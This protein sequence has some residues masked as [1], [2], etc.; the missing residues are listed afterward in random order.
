MRKKITFKI[1]VIN[2]LI[3]TKDI[4]MTDIIDIFKYQF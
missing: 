2:I 3:H 4:T 1:S